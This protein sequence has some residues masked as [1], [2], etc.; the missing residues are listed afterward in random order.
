M[1]RDLCIILE[2]FNGELCK[3][4]IYLIGDFGEKRRVLWAEFVG[5]VKVLTRDVAGRG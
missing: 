4:Q 3:N 1:I 5:D 2:G